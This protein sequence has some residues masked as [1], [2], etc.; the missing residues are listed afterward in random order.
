M[1]IRLLAAIPTYSGSIDSVTVETI[2]QLQRELLERGGAMQLRFHS[3]SVISTLR[4]LMVADFLASDADVLLMLDADQGITGAALMRMLDFGQPLVGCI[5]P[6]R[7]F[8]WTLVDPAQSAE[9][10]PRILYQASQYVGR[11]DTG[12]GGE[13]EV[14]D[15]FAPAIHVGTGI[16]LIRREVIETLARRYPELK[17]RGFHQ[18][19][20]PGPRFAQNWGFFNP[21]TAEDEGGAL[22][23]DF[24]FCHRWRAAGG[25]IWADIISHSAHVGRHVFGGNYYDFVKANG[26]R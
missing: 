1:S 3:G 25:Q 16:L 11:L 23:E 4:N 20:F 9:D 5:Y 22:S 2:V 13:I 8:D 26:P 6:K 24:S 17:E 7:V 12:P 18:A 14:R 19:D 15:G 10:M 21:L